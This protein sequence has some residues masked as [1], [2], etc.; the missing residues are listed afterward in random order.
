MIDKEKRKSSKEIQAKARMFLKEVENQKLITK[1]KNILDFDEITRSYNLG[2][3]N[4]RHIG[5]I[6][7]K[8]GKDT[9]HIK[10]DIRDVVKKLLAK[11]WKIK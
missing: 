9:E 2:E 5:F 8:G 3:Y 11:D 4:S 1:I 10:G 7:L 6:K